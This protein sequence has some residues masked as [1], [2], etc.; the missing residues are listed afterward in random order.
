MFAKL[1]PGTDFDSS[2]ELSSRGSAVKMKERSALR[3]GHGHCGRE[4][5][6]S[7]WPDRSP[8]SLPESTSSSQKVE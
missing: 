3:D 2:A 5:K 4:G 6:G 8:A 1:Q 7:G